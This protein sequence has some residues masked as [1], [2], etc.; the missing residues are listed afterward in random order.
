MKILLPFTF[1]TIATLGIAA[2]PFAGT[3][4]Q[5]NELSGG[6]MHVQHESPPILKIEV[7]EEKAIIYQWDRGREST[8]KYKLD[9][10]PSRRK[11][12]RW[13]GS[14]FSFKRVHSNVWH[15]FR[16]NHGKFNPES[17]KPVPYTQEGHWSV[18]HDGTVLTMSIL[19][20]YADGE[21]R[22]YFRVFEKQ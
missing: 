20:S 1:L 9:G 14:D 5:S 11:S 13:E 3:W 18:S 7:N 12:G 21:T 15:Y 10:T 2:D 8:E 22:Y 4:H 19:R 17:S 6:Q 16:D